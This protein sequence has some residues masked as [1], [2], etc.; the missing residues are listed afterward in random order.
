MRRRII[1]K[2]GDSP[3]IYGHLITAVEGDGDLRI[4]VGF[5]VSAAEVAFSKSYQRWLINTFGYDYQE[6]AF[7]PEIYVS[8]IDDEGFT[9]TY[10]NIPD[11]LEINYFIM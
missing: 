7:A 5:P 2:F 10:R 9:V 11:A 1:W 3:P 8:S 6:Y 4:I